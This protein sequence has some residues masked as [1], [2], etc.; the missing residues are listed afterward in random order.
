MSLAAEAIIERPLVAPV[1]AQ[2]DDPELFAVDE[3]IE[4]PAPWPALS[5]MSQGA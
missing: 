3:P 2:D 4:R 5:G 1:A